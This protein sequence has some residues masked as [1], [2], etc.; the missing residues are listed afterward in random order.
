MHSPSTLQDQTGRVKETS[1]PTGVGSLNEMRE[2]QSLADRVS[3]RI[4]DSLRAMR[5][6]WE[7]RPLDFFTVALLVLGAHSATFSIIDAFA[8]RGTLSVG[9]ILARSVPLLLLI[10]IVALLAAFKADCLTDASTAR[11]RRSRTR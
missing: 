5:F 1:S 3:P 6:R 4:E 8:G 2:V 11:R 10:V 7:G 9:V